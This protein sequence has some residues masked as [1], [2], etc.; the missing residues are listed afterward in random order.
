MGYFEQLLYNH[1]QKCL[2]VALFSSRLTR[3]PNR[4]KLTI[5]DTLWG[6]LL[7]GLR[8][9]DC[10]SLCTACPLLAEGFLRQRGTRGQERKQCDERG[11]SGKAQGDNKQR[12]RWNRSC[13]ERISIQNNFSNVSDAEVAAARKTRNPKADPVPL[14]TR[15]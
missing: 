5:E 14:G 11:F 12:C 9:P 1:T 8:L 2:T 7:S 15:S 3:S 10:T 4:F 13:S 6:P